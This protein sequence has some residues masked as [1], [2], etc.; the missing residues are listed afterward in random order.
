MH[1]VWREKLLCESWIS[2]VNKLPTALLILMTFAVANAQKVQIGFDRT[3]DITKYKTYNWDK[4]PASHN[5]MIAK[6]AMDAVDVALASKGFT[7]VENAGD[8]TVVVFTASES[9]LQISSP[10]WSPGLNSIHTGIAVP[11]QTWPVT[12]GTL[13]VDLLDTQTKS[14]VW[15]GTAMDTLSHNPTGNMAKD[16]KNAQKHIHKAVEK[17]FKKFPPKS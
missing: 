14:S 15:R 9:D 11:S 7:K 13:V 17:M 16:A 2:K 10:S 4:G 6:I 8:I 1:K 5:P 3:V 12:K